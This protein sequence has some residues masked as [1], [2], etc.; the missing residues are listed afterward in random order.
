MS[1]KT[2]KTSSTESS[3]SSGCSTSSMFELG[4]SDLFT[5]PYSSTASSSSD[6]S[7]ERPSNVST[8]RVISVPHLSKYFLLSLLRSV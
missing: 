7:D 5:T 8:N 1:M 2:T 6:E 4:S 3:S